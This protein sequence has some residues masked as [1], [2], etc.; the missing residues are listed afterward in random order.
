MAEAEPNRM[1][2]TGRNWPGADLL[3]TVK[4]TLNVEAQPPSEA[5]GWSDGLATTGGQVAC[6][7]NLFLVISANSSE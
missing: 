5:V 4:Q 2:A 3:Y 1:V 7:Q 6:I